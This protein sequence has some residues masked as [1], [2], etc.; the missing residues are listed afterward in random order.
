MELFV[1]YPTDKIQNQWGL[2]RAFGEVAE[3]HSDEKTLLEDFQSY[4]CDD[5]AGGAGSVT[6]VPSRRFS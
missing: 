6:L 1:G 2:Y 3:S 5:G 4:G